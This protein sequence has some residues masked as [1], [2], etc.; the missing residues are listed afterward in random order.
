MWLSIA[1][2]GASSVTFL[3]FL[4]SLSSCGREA[5]VQQQQINGHND[6]ST[7]GTA[8]GNSCCGAD[9]TP[10]A[11]ATKDDV[12]ELSEIELKLLQ[13]F[14]EGLLRGLVRPDAQLDTPL[15]L[16]YFAGFS[17][18]IT[19]KDGMGT[20][21]LGE[22]VTFEPPSAVLP[23]ARSKIRFNFSAK[24][25]IQKYGT[26]DDLIDTQEAGLKI[27]LK[28][29]VA[30]RPR[31]HLARIS[32]T[33][34]FQASTPI[35]DHV[36]WVWW[37]SGLGAFRLASAIIAAGPVG[38][39]SAADRI[40]VYLQ[41]LLIE[42]TDTTDFGSSGVRSLADLVW[43]RIG[44][45]VGVSAGQDPRAVLLLI[46]SLVFRYQTVEV[47]VKSADAENGLLLDVRCYQL[48]VSPPRE[49]D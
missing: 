22:L 28:A 20:T 18:F 49:G 2:P 44:N 6:A 25:L 42:F 48:P 32:E 14:D 7:G 9:T 11:A 3:V 19:G 16:T 40:L 31:T 17:G 10:A 27:A 15:F 38:S 41:P 30:Y 47:Q 29:G 24:C 35:E 36:A 21:K 12:V 23:V 4:V 37:P 39:F 1:K 43:W 8:W 46:D 26:R 34:S 5:A 13:S 33:G 45:Y